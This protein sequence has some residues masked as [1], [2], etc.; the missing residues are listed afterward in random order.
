MDKNLEQYFDDITNSEMELLSREEEQ[1][2]AKRIEEGDETARREL[3]EH[4]LRLVISIA[5]KY[6]NYGLDFEDLIQEGN[7]GLMKAVDKFDHTKGY[8]FSTYATWWIRQAIFRA[9]NDKSRTVRIPAHMSGLIRKINQAAERYNQENGEPPSCE[10]L[11]DMVDEPA[12]KVR[13]AR[14]FS[15]TTTSLDK[16]L[17]DSPNDGGVLGDILEDESSA[18]P[19]Q[20]TA[21]Q[22]LKDRL[23]FLLNRRLTDREKQILRLRYGL[24]DQHP[25]TLKETGKVFDLSRERIR[26][27]QERALKKLREADLEELEPY[28]EVGDKLD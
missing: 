24:E 13:R 15:Q 17:G 11:A 26:Q 16:P 18:S 19:E 20:V 1:D 5:K 27:L 22:M 14:R 4:N 12:E 23:K 10:E 8:K 7:T 2:L 25:R 21:D 6:R 3:A 9:L 28:F